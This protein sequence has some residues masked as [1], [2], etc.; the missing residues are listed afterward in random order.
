MANDTDEYVRHWARAGDRGRC[1]AENCDWMAGVG[2]IDV[3][4]RIQIDRA[5]LANDS[6]P[7]FSLEFND[8]VLSIDARCASAITRFRTRPALCEYVP[9]T[10]RRNTSEVALLMVANAPAYLFRLLRRLRA[11]SAGT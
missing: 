1:D 10:P 9:A 2:A 5:G 3:G 8:H 7:A 11:T 4:C 6:S